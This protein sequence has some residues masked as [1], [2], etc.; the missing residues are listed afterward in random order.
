MCIRDSSRTVR[1]TLA[2]SVATLLVAVSGAAAAHVRAAATTCTPDTA[3]GRNRAAFAAQVVT[4][5]NGYRT[6]IGRS[7]LRVSPAL[8]ASSVWKSLHMAALGYFAHDDPAPVSR[9][10]HQRAVDCGYA[11]GWWGENIA[12]GYGTARAVL[13][14]WLASPGHR[15]NIE[16][17]HFTSTGVGV[18]VAAGGRLYWTQ[19]F[20][21]DA[22]FA[23]AST[24]ARRKPALGAPPS[25]AGRPAAAAATRVGTGAALVTMQK[26]RS[27]IV[28]SASFVDRTTGRPLMGGSIGCRAEVDG[29]RLPVLARAFEARFVRCTWSLPRWVEGGR[30]TGAVAVRDAKASAESAFALT[31]A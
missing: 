20:G 15:A 30:L 17:P 19:S 10:A 2:V 24:T 8:T 4:L 29:K 18:A 6:G 27:R 14:A 16:N 25:G 1:R 31:L 28:A 26:D 21:D 12:V 23:V 13:D 22:G 11:G 7:R 3:W 9:S 5:V